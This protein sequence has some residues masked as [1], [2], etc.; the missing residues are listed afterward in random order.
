MRAFVTG[1]SGYIGSSVVQ[2]LLQ[3]G[4]EVVGLARSAE[5]A[6]RLTAAGADVHR[7][8][9]DDPTSLHAGAAAA[10]GVVHAAFVNDFSQYG[11]AGRIDLE[12]VRALGS[13]LIGTD[14]PLVVTSVTTLVTPGR[15]GREQDLPDSSSVS[16]T[17]APSEDLAISL[18]A[19]GV[20]SSAVRL[21]PSVHGPDDRHGFVP[22]LIALARE[23]GLSASVGAGDNRWPAVHRLDA[24]RLFRLA[25]ESAPAGTRLHGV[26][27]E[28]V[29]LREI[30][31]AVARGLDVPSGSVTVAE[32]EGYFGW[33]SMFVG[34]DNPTSSSATRGLLGWEPTQ[35]GLLSDIE[36]GHY[37]TTA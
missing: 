7:G 31:A 32:T 33:L 29:A 28:G 14:K 23:K 18:A 25:L 5:A 22:G 26:G 2:E 21:P 4:H 9:L 37:F 35:A 30:S 20:R 8:S 24:A 13:A 36:E 19:R 15:I 10:D 1:A 12:A 11:N 17:R 16:A 34:L 27:D 6:E 3:A